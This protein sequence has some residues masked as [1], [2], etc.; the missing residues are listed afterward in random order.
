M[1]EEARNRLF[2][3]MIAIFA[4]EAILFSAGNFKLNEKVRL[5]EVRKEEVRAS[6]EDL[7]LLAKATSVYDITKDEKIY[8]EN[9]EVALPIASL[10][11]IMTVTMALNEHEEKDKTI[12]ISSLSLKQSGDYGF[13]VG[14][15]W[16]IYDL[17]KITLLVSA[18]DGAYALASSVSLNNQDFL[19]KM[20][21]KAQKIGMQNTFF[22]N[23]TGLDFNQNKIELPMQIGQ[24]SAFA[25]AQDVNILTSYAF[26]AYPEIFA[27]TILPEIN[28]IS[29]SGFIYNFK[30][31]NTLI[32]KIPNLL[33]SK[34]GFTEKAGGS[35]TIIFKNK[36]DHKIAVTILGSTF[37]GRFSDMEKIVITL[38][39]Q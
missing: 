32:G 27:A 38:Y 28:L 35:L 36:D 2:V 23:F 22:F 37:E 26:R 18:N 24:A 25:S 21:T 5:E 13:R 31:T 30:N 19:K 34:T 7:P 16:N 33:F 4:L 3:F 10:V 20:N 1:K 12:D 17:A 15:K 39:D 29:E 8:G 11:K 14:E 9:D 6:L